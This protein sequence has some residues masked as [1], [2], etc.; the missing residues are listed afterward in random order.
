MRNSQRSHR[1]PAIVAW[2]IWRVGPVACI[3][4]EVSQV[5]K[6]S[7]APRRSAGFSLDDAARIRQMIFA[8]TPSECPQ[9]GFPLEATV[10]KDEG[11]GVWLVRC[12]GC[13]RSLVMQQP[14]R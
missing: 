5:L 2:V 14:R 8:G 7:N 11:R 3:I 4:G 10:G 1:R 12:H 9:C 6:V 13:G